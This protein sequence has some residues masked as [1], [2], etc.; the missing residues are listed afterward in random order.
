MS[1]GRIIRASPLKASLPGGVTGRRNRCRACRSRR[2]LARPNA[3]REAGE[4]PGLEVETTARY[5]HLAK[6]SVRASAVRVS[7]SIAGDLLP[8]YPGAAAD[9][10]CARAQRL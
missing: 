10:R 1:A 2:I 9:T 7:E 6:E 8:E 5:A 4:R 3:R